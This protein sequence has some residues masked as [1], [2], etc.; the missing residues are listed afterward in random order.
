MVRI[1]TSPEG[2]PVYKFRLHPWE[3]YKYNS[4]ELIV[5]CVTGIAA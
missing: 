4:V 2:Q 1:S 3:Q 5:L